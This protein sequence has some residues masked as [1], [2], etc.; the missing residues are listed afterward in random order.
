MCA[1]ALRLR[2][3]KRRAYYFEGKNGEEL[4]ERDVPEELEEQVRW[5]PTAVQM[6]Y[7]RRADA[8]QMPCRCRADAVQM[9]C[10]HA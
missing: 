8:V 9:P 10:T 3:V 4:V 2:Q 7:R 5:P 1:A 6:P